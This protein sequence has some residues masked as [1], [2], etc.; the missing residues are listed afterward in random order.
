[1][2]PIQVMWESELNPLSGDDSYTETK[3]E[4]NYVPYP[5]ESCR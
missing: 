5:Q 3:Y 4:S 1:M 2:H